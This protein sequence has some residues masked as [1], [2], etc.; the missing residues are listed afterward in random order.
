MKSS[1]KTNANLGLVKRMYNS[2]KHWYSRMKL[3]FIRNV[4]HSKR[5]E[6]DSSDKIIKEFLFHSLDQKT[7]DFLTTYFKEQPNNIRLHGTMYHIAYVDIKLMGST[8]GHFS[9]YHSDFPQKSST[10]LVLHDYRG[11]N[12]TKIIEY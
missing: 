10:F 8:Y 5:S 9:E 12:D 7:L 6:L 3:F 11:G 2:L 1:E 4:A